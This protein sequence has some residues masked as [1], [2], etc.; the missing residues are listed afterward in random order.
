[1]NLQ[2][3]CKS[4]QTTLSKLGDVTMITVELSSVANTY[5]QLDTIMDFVIDTYGKRFFE[6][7]KTNLN[8][9]VEDE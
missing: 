4:A 2:I 3:E 5:A 1:M 8:V 7:L 6:Y 9:E